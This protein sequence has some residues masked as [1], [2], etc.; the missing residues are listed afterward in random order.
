M[1]DFWLTNTSEGIK[2]DAD[3]RGGVGQAVITIREKK[4]FFKRNALTTS[5]CAGWNVHVDPSSNPQL[6]EY[7]KNIQHHQNI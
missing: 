5:Y 1:C 2:A 3:P 7:V 6:N 4:T